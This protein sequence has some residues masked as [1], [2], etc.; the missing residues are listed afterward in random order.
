MS[1]KFSITIRNKSPETLFQNSKHYHDEV[2]PQAINKFSGYSE[3]AKM[4]D[5]SFSF[6]NLD[7][8]RLKL[9]K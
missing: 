7:Y 5:R 2:K 1:D 9:L 3:S 6:I 8:V 4:E